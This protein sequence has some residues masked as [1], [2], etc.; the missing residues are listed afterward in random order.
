MKSKSTTT[1]LPLFKQSSSLWSP[2]AYQKKAVKF[3][4]EHAAAALF[5]DPGLGKT[6]IALAAVKLLIKKKL[7]T[8]VLLIA[9]LRVCYSVWP[10]ETEKW[11]DFKD[12]RI[13]ILHGKHKEANL[14]AEADIYVINPEGL[15]WLLGSEKS[16]NQLGR[17][18]VTVDVRQFKALG[19]DTLVIDELSKFKHTNTNRFKALKQVLNTFGRR[20]GLTGSPAS[21]GLMD[22]F[23]QCYVLDQGRTLGPYI[24]HYR[25]KYFVPGFDGFSWNLREGADAEI[26]ERVKPLAL[27]MAAEDYL[28]MPRLIENNIKVTLPEPVMRIY[29]QL[30]DDLIA[31]L[32]KSVVVAANAAAASMKCRQVAN[33]GVYLDQEVIALVKLPKSERE[34]VNLHGMK[35]DALADLVDELQGSPLL[36][37][38]DFEHDLDRIKAKLGDVPHIG[39]GVSIKAAKDLEAKWN[40]GELPVLLGH[41]QSVGHGL[42]LQGSCH[43][44]AWHSLTWDFELYD[45]FIRRVRRQGQKEGRVFVHHIMAA[46]TI[47]EVILMALKSKNRGQQALF[48]ALKSLR[49]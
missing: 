41:P 5:L 38:Y 15:D 27:R 39:G 20:W 22:L 16:K 33:G 25:M 17:T 36:V 30:E 48:Q 40:R 21:N 23:G 26:Y 9:P 45:Q 28:D 13:S 8:K 43:H 44:I 32:D 12:L 7:V 1:Q 19:F 4:L 37:A 24:S 6:S 3:L 10:A 31:K 29:K 46:G 34:W 49:K 18:K 35:V 42:N 2:H 11:S 14:K 47:D